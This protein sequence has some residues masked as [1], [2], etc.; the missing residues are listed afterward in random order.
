MESK[1]GTSDIGSSGNARQ[2]GGAPWENRAF[3]DERSPSHYVQRMQTPTLIVQGEADERCPVGQ[4]EQMFMSLLQAGCVVEFAR[5]PGGFH[6]FPRTAPPDHRED[7]L[8]R[9]LGWFR[10]YLGEPG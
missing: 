3:Y 8:A 9:V 6:P 2:W 7:F 5:Y 4:G 10:S 1:W